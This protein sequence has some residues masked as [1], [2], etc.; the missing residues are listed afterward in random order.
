MHYSKSDD[1]GGESVLDEIDKTGT[2]AKNNSLANEFGE[3][4]MSADEKEIADSAIEDNLSNEDKNNKNKTDLEA[5]QP[6]YYDEN[7]QLLGPNHGEKMIGFVPNIFCIK[8]I[9][10]W[11]RKW[12]SDGPRTLFHGRGFE[13]RRAITLYIQW[14]SCSRTRL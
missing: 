9:R 10:Y 11:S 4:E 7:I 6:E 8:K 12:G 5:K 2:K 14:S 1:T 3:K 13:A